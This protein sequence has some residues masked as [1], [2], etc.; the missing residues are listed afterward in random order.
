MLK[1]YYLG[2]FFWVPIPH[3]WYQNMSEFAAGVVG[4][5]IIASGFE[6]MVRKMQFA[7][8]FD[9]FAEHFFLIFV[10]FVNQT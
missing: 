9:N 2:G 1:K 10:K 6:L 7:I 8:H 3:R 4:R 5:W